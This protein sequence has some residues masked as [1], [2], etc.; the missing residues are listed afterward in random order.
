[1]DLKIVDNKML[2]VAEK[3]DIKELIEDFSNSGVEAYRQTTSFIGTKDTR[4]YGTYE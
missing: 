4:C 2:G 3:P 1:M